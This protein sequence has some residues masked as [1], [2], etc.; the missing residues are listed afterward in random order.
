MTLKNKLCTC[1]KAWHIH[2]TQRH[3]RY[4]TFATLKFYFYLCS[5]A[6][7]LIG[8]KVYAYH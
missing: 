7:L 4:M 8:E 5:V 6:Y 2:S 3:M 1:E